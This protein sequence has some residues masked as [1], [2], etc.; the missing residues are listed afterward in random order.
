MGD[1]LN[2]ARDRIIRE[3][4]KEFIG[5]GSEGYDGSD[6]EYERISENPLKRY[7]LGILYPQNFSADDEIIT[8]NDT[9]EGDLNI[10]TLESVADSEESTDLEMNKNVKIDEIAE[11]Q[12]IKTANQYCPS[13][14][15]VTF[16]VV[17]KS[18]V[19]KIKIIGAKYKKLN[20][21]E[22][23][24][25]I[26]EEDSFIY[27]I[28]DKEC[29][30]L[31]DSK[32]YYKSST[33][34]AYMRDLLGD[35]YLRFS[36]IHDKAKNFKTRGYK[37]EPII[38]Y[39]DQVK[40]NRDRIE[41]KTINPDQ[42]KVIINCRK[43]DD[44]ILKVTISVIN[45]N[46]LTDKDSKYSRPELCLF[47]N[48]IEITKLDDTE[49]T[50]INKL[51]ISPSINRVDEL[52]YDKRRIYAVGHGCS[53]DWDHK[54][55]PKVISSTFI[56]KYEVP[57]VSSFPDRINKLNL[58][59]FSMPYLSYCKNKEEFI[60]ELH[61]LVAD[62][63]L[64]INELDNESSS[65]ESHK[66][67]YAQ[68]NIKECMN[69]KNSI[70][71]GLKILG[72]ND[73]AWKAFQ[74][75][76]E[77]M[78]MQ[79]Y[80]TDIYV[81]NP[82]NIDDPWKELPDEYDTISDAIAKWRPF[83]LMFI[84]MN[85]ES[86]INDKSINRG[87]ADLLWFPTGGGKTE[88]YLGVIAFTIFYRRLYYQNK[89][90]GTSVIMR[91]TLRLL[92]SQQYERASTLIAACEVIRRRTSSLLGEEEISIGLWVGRDNTPNNQ[93]EA[94][95]IIS[96]LINNKNDFKS[97]NPFQVINCPWC[98]TQIFNDDS[99]IESGY[100]VSPEFYIKCIEE[101]CPF[102]SRLPLQV[103]DEHLYTNPPTLL[104]A[105]VD[106]FARLAWE[107]RCKS[108][109]G[110]S[111]SDI[112][113]KYRPPEI[114]LQ[115][116]LHL[117]SGPLGSM[118]GIYEA[119]IDYLCTYD[120]SKPK[121][122]CSTAT[123]KRADEQINALFNRKTRVFPPAGIDIS[124]NY[125]SKEISTDIEPGRTYI[126]LMSVGITHTS[127]QVKILSNLMYN[128][129][130]LDEDIIDKYYT[131]VAYFNTIKELGLTATLID[132]DVY[133]KI[134][135]L[136]ARY[137]KIFRRQL[138]KRELT[139]REISTELPKILKQ[140]ENIRYPDNKAIP[141][142]L[143]TNMFSVGVDISRLNL[144]YVAGQP[145]SSSEY[146]QST[147]RVGRVDPGLIVVLLDGFRPRD[148]S[149]YENFKAFH[150]SFYRFV[151][152]AG[153]TPFSE[154][155]RRRA[156]H[157]LLII[158]VRIKYGLSGNEEAGNFNKKVIEDEF[159]N[160]INN[161]VKNID[162][163]ELEDMKTMFSILL[164]EW[165]NKADNKL[166]YQIKYNPFNKKKIQT[167]KIPL[168]ITYEEKSET[169]NTESWPVLNSLR[170]VDIPCEC[171]LKD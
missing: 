81:R 6:D 105:T 154:P 89:G 129:V 40:L 86:I 11:E 26:R 30:E 92:T 47:Q 99:P 87:V 52:L 41:L 83:Q 12:S 49:Y 120:G 93:K 115:D 56:P 79:R 20:T 28:S 124:D 42:A 57:K 15:G 95:D 68:A 62:Y 146:I 51:S 152:P 111:Q 37:R 123:I 75:A 100:I 142:I 34:M 63:Q 69:I 32:Y 1:N 127:A 122:I 139:S 143:S 27:S 119:I 18:P 76:N 48:K 17:N 16:F 14:Y 54:I 145:K 66:K 117:I 55:E 38:I 103:I 131:I 82:R 104:F 85:I 74:L 133:E 44:G 29:F 106:K 43:S 138:W 13:S 7:A 160:Y 80:H 101:R 9:E 107:P 112:K 33:N 24:V 61:S 110:F 3:I 162:K 136:Q 169:I 36:R 58:K 150:Q 67:D 132:A 121:I 60:H 77:A 8:T 113:Y 165:N 4:E 98:G 71:D 70:L 140:L 94:E 130:L 46:K 167:D 171:I 141:I 45:N 78:T 116:E 91:Y 161:R 90:C 23:F 109:F 163:D 64:W 137:R 151:E 156:F 19:V 147:S 114:I 155:A 84:I 126:G 170:S 164:E 158:L 50:H 128:N 125:Y 10:E 149:H 73:I 168:M 53:V 148:R 35:N 5:P 39:D 134:Q 65:Y 166:I 102:N 88:A 108:F 22:A 25:N 157:A 135:T 97:N 72:N 2:Q 144:M 59:I 159:I 96:N 118:F 31:E 21:G 153:V